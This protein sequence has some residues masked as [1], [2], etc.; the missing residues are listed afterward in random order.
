MPPGTLHS[1]FTTET[2]VC[3]GGHFY[4]WSTM[5]HT[6]WSLIH[7]RVRDQSTNAEHGIWSETLVR[8]VILFFHR[9]VR[10]YDRRKWFV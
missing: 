6:L 5:R 8:I 10:G 7:V 1:V 9:Y 4:A 3:S 2:S